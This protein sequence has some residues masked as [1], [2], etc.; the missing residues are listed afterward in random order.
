MTQY[1]GRWV[2]TWTSLE[3]TNSPSLSSSAQSA[4]WRPTRH[5]DAQNTSSSRHSPST[6]TAFHC[7]NIARRSIDLPSS[8]AALLLTPFSRTHGR[9][10]ALH[11]DT[12][13]CT[14]HVPVMWPL[15][16]TRGLLPPAHD[17]LQVIVNM[18]SFLVYCFKSRV[19]AETRTTQTYVASTSRCIL[20]LLS[21][22]C[23]R[24]NDRSWCMKGSA[25]LRWPGLRG[26]KRERDT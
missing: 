12:S 17:I 1:S 21:L 19:E 10:A 20:S 6:Y 13:S 22:R 18:F 8:Y 26:N 4:E 16:H 24:C 14:P 7:A 15:G 3:S 9:P 25:V 11:I 23:I 5:V 2:F